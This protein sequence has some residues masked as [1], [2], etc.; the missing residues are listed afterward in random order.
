MNEKWK[1]KYKKEWINENSYKGMNGFYLFILRFRF[2]YNKSQN[3]MIEQMEE[4][5]V[6]KKNVLQNEWMSK[7]KKTRMNKE[8]ND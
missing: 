2:Y 3:Q 1:K 4:W 8:I 6:R 7:W 5:K